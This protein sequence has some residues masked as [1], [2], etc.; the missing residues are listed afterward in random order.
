MVRTTFTL[1]LTQT[2]LDCQS[3]PTL[4][5]LPFACNVQAQEQPTPQLALQ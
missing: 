3:I 1:A 4:T 5:Q 2:D